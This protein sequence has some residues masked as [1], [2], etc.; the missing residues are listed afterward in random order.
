MAELKSYSCPKCGGFLDVD[1]DQDTFDCPFC[2][3]GFNVLDFHRDDLLEEARKQVYDGH[4]FLIAVNEKWY[5]ALQSWEYPFYPMQSEAYR[6]I[7]MKNGLLDADVDDFIR[8]PS[9]N[10]RGD[11]NPVAIYQLV[12]DI[13]KSPK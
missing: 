5:N 1:R 12:T 2:G 6:V 11:Y 3:A 8:D 13:Y 10:I 9:P 7:A 4:V